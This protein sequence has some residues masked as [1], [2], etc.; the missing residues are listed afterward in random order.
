MIEHIVVCGIAAAI[1]MY[2]YWRGCTVWRIE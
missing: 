2:G 1:F